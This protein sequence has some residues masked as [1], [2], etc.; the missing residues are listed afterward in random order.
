MNDAPWVTTEPTQAAGLAWRCTKIHHLTPAETAG[1]HN[2]FIWCVIGGN[3]VRD[4]S[5]QIKWGWE[6]QRPGELSPD[7][8][9]DKRAPDPSTDIPIE[10]GQHIWCRVHDDKHGFASDIVRNLHA[11]LPGPGGG[12]D[13]QHH[14][15]DVYFEL[16]QSNVVPPVTPPPSNC[17]EVVKQL[18]DTQA[19]L[20]S[21]DAILQQMAALLKQWQAV[22]PSSQ[23]LRQSY[24]TTGTSVNVVPSEDVRVVN[25]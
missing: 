9:C 13:W 18:A 1:R 5:L 7:K 3:V 10:R 25:G 21:R 4:G 2:V 6:G 20:A 11:E 22:Q 24:V 12:S 16:I 15:Y 19:K 17:D 8:I 14:S 23:A